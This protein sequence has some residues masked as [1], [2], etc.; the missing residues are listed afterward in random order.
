MA[1]C[2]QNFLAIILVIEIAHNKNSTFAF[3]GSGISLFGRTYIIR[4]FKLLCKVFLHVYI[5]TVVCSG[6]TSRSAA[7]G[8]AKSRASL[9]P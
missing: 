6:V 8:G 2:L 4:S 5:D 1:R 7:G 9:G 3:S